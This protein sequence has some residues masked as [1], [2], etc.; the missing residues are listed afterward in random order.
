MVKCLLVMS[1]FGVHNKRAGQAKPDS[2][3]VAFTFGV[4]HTGPAA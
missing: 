1:I 2:L 3:D 4:A